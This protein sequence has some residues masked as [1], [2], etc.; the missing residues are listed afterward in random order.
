DIVEIWRSF[1]GLGFIFAM[2]MTRAESLPLDLAA[3][4]DEGVKNIPAIAANYAAQLGVSSEA[5]QEYL[6]SN[7]AYA[8]DDE[9]LRGMD[10]YFSLAHEH[11]LIPAVRDLQCSN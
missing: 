11:G 9:M 5:M 10:L 1:T 7:I 8:P 3:A 6:S 2:W 4:R